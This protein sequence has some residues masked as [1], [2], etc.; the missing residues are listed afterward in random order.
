[1]ER[2]RV[3][4]VRCGARRRRARAHEGRHRRPTYRSCA[5]RGR[6]RCADRMAGTR[7]RGLRRAMTAARSI[8]VRGIV[9]G[10][11][12][13]PFVF[14]LARANGLAGWVS[15]EESGVTIHVEG[16]ERRMQAFLRG[17]AGHPP[18]A[19][20][21]T[22]IDVHDAAPAGLTAFTIRRSLRR[23]TPTVR[24]SPDLT[25]CDDCLREMRE[26][27][28]PR[29]RYPYINCV[30]CGPRYSVIER[31]PYDRANTTMSAWAMDDLCAAQYADPA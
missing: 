30:N 23:A 26:P 21:I 27:A 10:V 12:F 5:V 8:R 18:P 7:L 28:D 15:N 6:A 9:Q 31:L 2:T 17:L 22:D 14:R 4:R 19:A 11:G 20:N 29:Y 24:I 16:D 13:R 25:V 3:H 1:M